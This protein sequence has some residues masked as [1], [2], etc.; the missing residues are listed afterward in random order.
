M[1]KSE[2]V[3]ILLCAMSATARAGTI[4]GTVSGPD[5]A[6]IAHA[7]I[8]M[9]NS[10]TGADIRRYSSDDGKFVV[11]ELNAGAYT[12][13]VAMPCCSYQPF[14]SDIITLTNSEVVDIAIEI[15][16][17]NYLIALADDPGALAAE[18]RQRRVLP[19]A[20]VPETNGKPDLSGVWLLDD[21][22]FPADPEPL[23]WAAE[24]AATRDP[25]DLQQDLFARCLPGELPIPGAAIPMITKFVHSGDLLVM[26]F[27]GPPGFRQIFLDGREHPE[28]PNPSWLGHSV[29][30]WEGNTL[31]VETIGFD[32]RGQSGDY[33]RSDLMRLEERY[34]RT[35]FGYMELRMTIDDPGV[36]KKPWVRNLHLDLVP[37]EELIE[38]VCENNKWLDDGE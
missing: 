20:P 18:L 11:A 19:D 10:E 13:S 36:F 22:P 15:E 5:G 8:R 12:I 16:P 35:E 37:Q 14:T 17:A 2:T 38:F 9:V 25:D 6:A 21:D 27:E 34:T 24:V 30:R 31:V 1:G 3:L 29:G 4:S 33:P 7:P 28:Y 23:P 26:L 32:N